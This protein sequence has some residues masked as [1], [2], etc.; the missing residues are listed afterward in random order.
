[1]CNETVLLK[2]PT[3]DDWSE[4]E[5]DRCIAPLVQALN[6]GGILTSSCCCG[7]GKELGHIWLRDGRILAIMPTG[8]GKEEVV[9]TLQRD[10]SKVL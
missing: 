9:E 6:D 1:M 8:T 5:I 10:R 2:V 4:Q 3:C 7:H